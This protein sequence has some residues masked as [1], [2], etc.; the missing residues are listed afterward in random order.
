[1]CK[2]IRL[3]LDRLKWEQMIALKN[4]SGIDA[5]RS[6][7]QLIALNKSP[8]I[9]RRGEARARG[10]SGSR[11]LA[12]A[13]VRLESLTYVSLSRLTREPDRETCYAKSRNVAADV[14]L[15]TIAGFA[16]GSGSKA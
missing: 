13:C 11:E 1:M 14:Q 12:M 10:L 5:R 2:A 6:V 15:T 3:V 8:R 16:D 9:S 4:S 7:R